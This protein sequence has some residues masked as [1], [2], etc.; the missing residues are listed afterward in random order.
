[1]TEKES[2]DHTPADAALRV[3]RR[4][5]HALRNAQNAAFVNLEVVR[6]RSSAGGANEGLRQFTDNAAKAIEDAARLADA[7]LA[8]ASALITALAEDNLS[9]DDEPAGKH[10]HLEIRMSPDA[11]GALITTVRAA[12]DGLGV[13][14]EASARG[15]ILRIPR[16]HDAK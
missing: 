3:M 11:A 8:M 5:A 1:V 4:S 10:R 14:I 12:G 16:E 7:M 15:A 2:Q 9:L 6:S 13:G